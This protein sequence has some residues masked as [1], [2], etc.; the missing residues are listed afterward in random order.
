MTIEIKTSMLEPV[1]HTFAHIERRFGDKPATRYQEATYD[2][3]S[4]TNFH[5]RPLWQ[6]DL[7]LNDPRRTDIQMNDWYAFKDPRQFYYGSYVQ[8]RAKMQEAA[9]NNYAFFEKR[10]LADHLSEELRASLIR[11]LVP[12]RHV[13]HTANLN[14]V[15]GAAY[16]YGTAITQA[17][18]FD[19]MDR[20]GMAQY[21]SRIGL[22]LDGN[23]GDSLV[24]AK[25]QW[26]SADIWQGVRAICEE[27]LVTKDWF[28][29]L[30]AQDFVIDNL[31]ANLVYEQWDEKL[32]ENGGQDVAMLTEFMR[33]WH[34]D[35]ARWVDAVIKVAAV[36]S[37]ENQLLISGWVTKWRG[38]AA[39]AFA[40]LCNE[41]LSEKALTDA[42]SVM[43][44][45]L[46][47]AGIK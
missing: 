9:E 19:G 36:E 44:K 30:I 14:N 47:K 27:M 29:L 22:I 32:A 7:E 40:P 11:F 12:F 15:Y 28:E 17:L 25:T 43:D 31:V 1:R 42:L 2:V 38:K 34:K 3:Q 23:S 10:N 45:R 37:D 33:V 4:E 21:L 20:L 16:G 6:P 13:E 26:M 18:M 39:E 8:Q 41:M 35:T 24:E 5:Y 46:A